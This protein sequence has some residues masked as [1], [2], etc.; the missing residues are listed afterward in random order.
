MKTITRKVFSLCDDF[1]D[2]DMY[3][4]LSDERGCDC[5]IDYTAN[6]EETLREQGYDN[7][8]IANHLI[9]L[10]AEDNEQVLIHIDY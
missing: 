2:E 10:G 4:K 1:E 7:D 6:T 8:I 3:Q 5:Y 9:V